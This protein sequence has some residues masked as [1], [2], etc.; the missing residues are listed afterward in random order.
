MLSATFGDAHLVSLLTLRHIR[1][2]K[3]P[4]KMEILHSNVFMLDKRGIS[5]KWLTFLILLYF[6]LKCRILLC[7]LPRVKSL[8]DLVKDAFLL[9]SGTVNSVH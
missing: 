4:Y 8:T 7:L 5:V 6:K 1:T 9:I 3:Y 2:L